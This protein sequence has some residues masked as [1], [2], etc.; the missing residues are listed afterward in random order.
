[1]AKPLRNFP[2]LPCGDNRQ[3]QPEGGKKEV[4]LDLGVE[5]NAEVD[6]N[7]EENDLIQEPWFNISR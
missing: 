1:M 5:L 6:L 2:R 7:S 4:I 3:L